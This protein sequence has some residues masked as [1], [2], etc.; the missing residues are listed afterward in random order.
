M[1]SNNPIPRAGSKDIWNAF[2]VKDATFTGPDIPLCPT[3]LN[4]PPEKII[5]WLDAKKLHKAEMKRD[6][7]YHSD[8]FIC[9]YLD[10]Q[11]FDGPRSSIWL[12]P[13]QALRI[14]KHFRGIITPDFSTFQDFPHPLKIFNTYRMR[15][16]GYWIG[17]QGLEV[18]NNVRWGTPETF[19][20][21][22][23]GIEKN[24]VVAIGTVGGS[25]RKMEN[26]ERFELGLYEMA[27]RLSPHSIIIYGSDKYPCFSTLKENGI[28]IIAFQS[29]T[30]AAF[31]RRCKNEQRTERPL[32]ND[33][34]L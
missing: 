26:R 22:F 2:M 24:S 8:S 16:F 33:E 31:E 29:H 18:I 4:G 6:K 17:K 23:E 21:C 30:D 3:I 15:A 19:D 32:S 12:F 28:N 27:K 25:P 34:R 9:F 11:C 14:I 1:K 13:K 10:D 20:Y 5:T 7:N